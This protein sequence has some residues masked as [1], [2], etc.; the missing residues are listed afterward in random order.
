MLIGPQ[1]THTPTGC[2]MP[3]QKIYRLAQHS[4]GASHMLPCSPT[5]S[6]MAH[7]E[8]LSSLPMHSAL[9]RHCRTALWARLKTQQPMA[10]SGRPN[11][12]QQI[13]V[14]THMYL[15]ERLCR[16]R[17]HGTHTLSSAAFHVLILPHRCRTALC[18]QQL[19]LLTALPFL[20][21]TA[22]DTLAGHAPAA[23]G[24]RPHAQAPSTS[25]QLRSPSQSLSHLI[26][27]RVAPL[28][29]W[30]PHSKMNPTETLLQPW[31]TFAA[32]HAGACKAATLGK[33]QG[34]LH[35]TFSRFPVRG[36]KRILN[37]R[38]YPGH[39]Q[40]ALRHCSHT[41]GRAQAI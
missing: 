19:G 29:G 39:K 10:T 24:G 23:R 15:Q 6:S 13:S 25:K 9:L 3:M 5:P 8:R 28:L 30:A 41:P 36:H 12:K 38:P 4:S 35:P 31:N 40:Y 17:L 1:S 27:A 37:T 18:E 2:C 21:T 16:I 14:P 20:N 22:R 32:P 11:C 26:P 34:R 33:M 7:T